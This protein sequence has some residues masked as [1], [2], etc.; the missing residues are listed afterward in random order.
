MEALRA[1]QDAGLVTLESPERFVI[2]PA[3][4]SLSQAYQEIDEQRAQAAA[5]E[6]NTQKREML[7][8]ILSTVF[9]ALLTFLLERLL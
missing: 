1:L 9:G 6:R 2:T 8:A 3:G 7:V 4:V 5:N